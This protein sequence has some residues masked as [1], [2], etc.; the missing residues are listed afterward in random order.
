MAYSLTVFHQD[1]AS[2]IS[3]L[4][5][6][7]KITLAATGEIR[8]AVLSLDNSRGRFTTGAAKISNEDTIKVT[9]IDS[10]SAQKDIIFEVDAKTP[11]QNIPEG[12]SAV[13]EMLATERNLQ[14]VKFTEQFY[15]ADAFD[16]AKRII[17][18]Y[19]LNAGTE[20]PTISEHNDDTKNKLP[21]WTANHHLYNL[22]ETFCYDGINELVDSLGASVANAGAGDFFEFTFE[23]DPADD[24]NLIFRA[25]SSGENPPTPITITDTVSVNP[26]PNEGGEDAPTGTLIYAKG[27]ENG[28]LPV[29]TSRFFGIQEAFNLHP[30][31][32]SGLEYPADATVQKNEI[33]YQA[34]TLT[35]NDP[36]HAD[37]TVIL[38]E[39][40]LGDLKYSKYTDG[41]ANAWISSGSNPNDGA[42]GA[43]GSGVDF[44]Q[45]GC[46]DS[47]LIIVDGDHARFWAK[48]KTTT[49]N[50][51]V[52]YKYS[53]ISTGEFEGLI[54]LV[55][56][57]GTDGFAG[58]DINGKPYSNSLAKFD[59]TNW[60]VIHSFVDDEQ[61]SIIHEGKVYELQSGTWV[62]I[63][64]N[65]DKGNDPFHVYTACTNNQGINATPKG[66]SVYGVQSA[67]EYQYDYSTFLGFLGNI[68]TTLDYYKAGAWANIVLAPFP[69]NSYRGNTLGS[70]YGNNS[71]LKQPALLDANNMH[72][73]HSGFVGF[74]NA[75]SEDF[76][77][78]NSVN[79]WIKM[80]WTDGLG[81]KMIEGDFKYRLTLYDIFGNVMVH[82]FVIGRNDFWE[83][84]SLPV[85][86]FRPYRARLPKRWGNI[87]PNL[88][89]QELE[90]LN[91]FEWRA[92][93][94]ACIQWQEAYD[95]EGRFAP[96][97]SRI[98]TSPFFTGAGR[99]VLSIDMFHFGKTLTASTPPVTARLKETR[100]LHFPTIPNYVQLQ[101]SVLAQLEIEQQPH[102]QFEITTEGA[103][104]I[105]VGDSFYFENEKMVD[106]SDNGLNTIRLVA[107]KIILSFTKKDGQGGF[108]RT[109]LG[110]KKRT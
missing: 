108:L 10:A 15:F 70:L 35:S 87:G 24:N 46:W 58:N 51:D 21:K 9:I 6:D 109:I 90:I 5:E 43:Q 71:T 65:T 64:S 3:D 100:T 83:Y 38:V 39:D 105:D 11:R 96:E 16:V 2:D 52:K 101:Q 85:S 95:D 92:V 80:L 25:F 99:T 84:K 97:N 93:K 74:N 30:Q 47:N 82:D 49:D 44:D 31:H 48:L 89:L 1:T 19:N 68:F 40:V 7:L 42:F 98:I 77:P 55:N 61:C 104:D 69:D 72:Y 110:V 59:G 56:G 13:F 22:Q 36:P 57:T 53:E 12:N 66:G 107:K 91:Q 54:V 81:A 8:S 94:M 29:D 33:H 4:V 102:T 76:S 86:G 62:D 73:T 17:D 45:H 37:W 28:S 88:I 20:Q 67:V 14:V 75:E 26:A 106:D 41:Q 78:L 34:N 60:I 79:F 103:L 63:S 23:N 32:V 50:F 27:D 18:Q